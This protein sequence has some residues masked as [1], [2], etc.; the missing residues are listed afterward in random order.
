MGLVCAKL[1]TFLMVS[2]RIN[3]DADGLGL[4]GTETDKVDTGKARNSTTQ[5]GRELC[6][7]AHDE[8]ISGDHTAIDVLVLKSARQRG[9]AVVDVPPMAPVLHQKHDYN[10]VGGDRE[11][12]WRG[13]EAEEN[14]RLYGGERQAYS[15]LSVTQ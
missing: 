6:N 3:V 14:F 1:A 11:Q 15:L 8:G 2:K 9:V 13:V 5:R 12:V 10:H 7:R 4:D